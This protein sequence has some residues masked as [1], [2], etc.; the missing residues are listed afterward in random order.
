[1]Q[2]ILGQNRTAKAA[3]QFASPEF[4]SLTGVGGRGLIQQVRAS[5]AR[6]I[7][8][9]Y[10]VGD[11]SVYWGFQG[12]EGSLSVS[13]FVGNSFF[14]GA[15]GTE[16]GIISSVIGNVGGNDCH[17]AGAKVTFE[18]LALLDVGFQVTAGETTIVESLNFKVGNLGV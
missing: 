15:S 3:K 16:C 5:Y 4:F 2:N 11:S 17:A 10:V 1:M 8:S 14:S 13:R 6:R 12:G 9:I 7:D 18:Q